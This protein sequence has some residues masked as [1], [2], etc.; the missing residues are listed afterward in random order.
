MSDKPDLVR[1]R[2]LLTGLALGLVT[3]ASAT[4]GRLAGPGGVPDEQFVADALTVGALALETSH[5]ARARSPNPDVRAFARSEI[6]EQ[7][8]IAAS[9]SGTGIAPVLGRREA[10]MIERH[11]ALPPGLAFDRTYVRGKIMGHRELFAVNAAYA[12]SGDEPEL[13]AVARGA[14]PLIRRHLGILNG[15]DASLVA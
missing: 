5:I 15:I 13:V 6:N 11:R 4:Y 14:L 1:R 10:A 12:R 2:I 8:G 3:P 9:L 7:R